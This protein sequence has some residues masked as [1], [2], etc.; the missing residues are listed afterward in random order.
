MIPRNIISTFKNKITFCYKAPIAPNKTTL[1]FIPGFHSDFITSKKSQLV[2]D[3]A[4]ENNLGFLSWN[5][6][7]EAKSIVEWYQDGI[8]L[9]KEYKSEKYYYIGA[10]M[11]LWISLLL[12]MRGYTPNGIISIGGGIDFTERW[13]Q[14]EVPLEE[15]EN[16]NY[17]W[18][19]PSEYDPNGYYAIPISFLYESRP[20]LIMSKHKEGVCIDCPITLLHGSL[21]KDVPLE[22]A[23]K[24]SEYLSLMSNVT[25]YEIIGGNH[26]LSRSQDLNT[27]CRQMKLMIQQQQQ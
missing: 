17:V 4:V 25:F 18:K 20:A 27:I 22:L 14:N 3:Y 26:Q 23:V 16:K 15:R 11:G 7:N 6:V 9:I 21:D 8:E 19:R 5:H 1:C 24:T 13:L 10:S 12:S 2:Y